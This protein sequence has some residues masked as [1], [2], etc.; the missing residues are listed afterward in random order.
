MFITPPQ[1]R[2]LSAQEY[3]FGLL[4]AASERVSEILRENRRRLDAGEDSN[5]IR[6]TLAAL[7]QMI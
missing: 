2:L 6:S 1:S 7:A 5:I 4:K 3:Q